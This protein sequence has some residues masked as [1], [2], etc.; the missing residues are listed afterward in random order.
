MV[1]VTFYRLQFGDANEW[2]VWGGGTGEGEGIV[3]TLVRAPMHKSLALEGTFTYVIPGRNQV[4]NLDGQGQASTFSPSAWNVAV[5]VVWYP[6]GRSRRSLSSPYRPLFEVADNG[7][8]IRS[9][10]PFLQ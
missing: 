5:N 9:I 1:R 7:S 6:A 10:E 3:G 4:I 8:M 2:K